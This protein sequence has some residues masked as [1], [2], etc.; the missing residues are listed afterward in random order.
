MVNEND[1]TNETSDP[2]P[3][4]A[5]DA[6]DLYRYASDPEIGPPCGWRPHTSVENSRELIGG[7]LSE[8]ETYAVCLRETDRAIGS[9]GLH[10]GDLAVTEDEY[11]WGTG[12]ASPFGGR[13]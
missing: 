2:A 4:L 6:E 7:V 12:S 3:W 5:E 9:I 8:P 11:D 1:L 10:R 13:V